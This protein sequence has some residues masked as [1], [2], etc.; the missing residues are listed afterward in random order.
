MKNKL[1]TKKNFKFNK[2]YAYFGDDKYPRYI[3]RGKK[4]TK[5]Q[6]EEILI[7]EIGKSIFDNVKI[8]N[9]KEENIIKP[10]SIRETLD[11]EERERIIKENSNVNENVED[12]DDENNIDDLENWFYSPNSQEFIP[13][14]SINS[15]IDINGNVGADGN[16]TKYPMPF[17]FI[18]EHLEY[19]N[20][21][22]F[23]NY[24][25]IYIDYDMNSYEGRYIDDLYP[26]LFNNIKNK[27][28][29]FTYALYVHDGGIE[30][31]KKDEAIKLYNKYQKQYKNNLIFNKYHYNEYVKDTFVAFDI[32]LILK[33]WKIEKDLKNEI[34][35][36]YKEK[37]TI[38][39]IDRWI[40]NTKVSFTDKKYKEY[41]KMYKELENIK[42][43]KKTNLNISKDMYDLL[44]EYIEV[45][46]KY[47]ER[48]NKVKEIE[49]YLKSKLKRNDYR[50]IREVIFDFRYNI[51]ILETAYKKDK[52][53]INNVFPKI[54]I[55][56]IYNSRIKMYDEL[57]H[58]RKNEKTVLKYN[59]TVLNKIKKYLSVTVNI[60]GSE[61]E[62]K[63]LEYI[64]KLEIELKNKLDKDLYKT[65]VDTILYFKSSTYDIEKEYKIYC[66]GRDLAISFM[67][68]VKNAV[69]NK[70]YYLTSIN[71]KSYLKKYNKLEKEYK[72]IINNCLIY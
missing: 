3:L 46:F 22:P 32:P 9:Y 24:V 65:L 21:Y 40:K 16:T 56:N 57:E 14:T 19:A 7:T 55:D 51:K 8:A 70:D 13:N 48:M 33:N 10:L 58:I 49:K 30:V 5:E 42:N 18:I 4:I 15:F 12:T 45:V 2:K 64:W 71:E 35:K 20:K 72:K 36:V 34:K 31:I 26:P 52:K 47:H 44:K 59:K 28:K 27:L 39:N 66:D 17:E 29:G 53:D 37:N 38:S 25:I 23:L 62:R 69:K 11:E 61:K 54:L 6:A 63:E 41:K 50:R 43:N 60:D 68:E 67:K 1:L